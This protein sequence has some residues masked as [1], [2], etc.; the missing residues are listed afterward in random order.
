MKPLPGERIPEMKNMDTAH[1][2]SILVEHNL[3]RTCA[4]SRIADLI[5]ADSSEYTGI[6]NNNDLCEDKVGIFLSATIRYILIWCPS[7]SNAFAYRFVYLSY[8]ILIGD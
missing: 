4:D 8:W 6:Q 5:G 7:F 3:I 2:L 1:M